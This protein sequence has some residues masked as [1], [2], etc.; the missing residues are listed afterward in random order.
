[1]ARS[2]SD[3]FAGIRPSD[4]PLFIVAQIAGASCATLLFRRLV[5]N[6]AEYAEQVV[7]LIPLVANL[8]KSVKFSITKNNRNLRNLQLFASGC[9]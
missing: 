6:L 9:V 2:L 1:M 3:T 5:P 8:E 7:C 4:V